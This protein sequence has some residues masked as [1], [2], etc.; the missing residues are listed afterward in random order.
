MKKPSADNGRNRRKLKIVETGA[1]LEHKK[2]PFLD[3]LKTRLFVTQA[4]DD[5]GIARSTVYLWRDEDQKF[6]AAMDEVEGRTVDIARS[7]AFRRGVVGYEEPQAIAGRREMV[8]KYSD[9]LLIKV[10]QA[11]DP[12]YRDGVTAQ[13]NISLVQILVGKLQ[14]LIQRVIPISCPHCGKTLEARKNMAR[15]LAHLDTVEA[16]EADGG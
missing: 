13:I 4:A 7:E 11:R 2:I 5:V 3:A 15:E 16:V 1:T 8:R 6:R 10:L 14:S 9:Q 12:A